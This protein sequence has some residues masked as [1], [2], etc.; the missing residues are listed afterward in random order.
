MHP[1]PMKYSTSSVNLLSSEI[2]IGGN[3]NPNSILGTNKC[4][5]RIIRNLKFDLENKLKSQNKK[6]TPNHQSNYQEQNKYINERK[7]FP[8]QTTA[9]QNPRIKVANPEAISDIPDNEE[10]QDSKKVTGD[11]KMGRTYRSSSGSRDG[12]T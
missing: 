4:Y 9:S 2:V 10:T 5:F 7:L 3:K 8:Q 12:K 1:Q 6:K 11:G